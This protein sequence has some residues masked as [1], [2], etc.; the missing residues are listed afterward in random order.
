MKVKEKD[1]VG[2]EN[3]KQEGKWTEMEKGYKMA[4]GK[5]K[6]NKNERK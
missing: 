4:N 5:V 1:E 3:G 2:K 6:R